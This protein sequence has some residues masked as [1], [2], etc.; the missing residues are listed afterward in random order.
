MNP[1]LVMLVVEPNPNGAIVE[2]I[3][4]Y[5]GLGQRAFVLTENVAEGATCSY[6][7]ATFADFAQKIMPDIKW[8]DDY[9][10][11]RAFEEK[12]KDTAPT[13]PHSDGA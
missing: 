11:L 3:K 4:Q 13:D 8:L 10:R 12:L 7:I 6:Q 1:S 5:Q 9:K 2:R